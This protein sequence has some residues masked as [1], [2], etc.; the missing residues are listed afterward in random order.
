[1]KTLIT[2]VVF[3]LIFYASCGPVN[4]WDLSRYK[5]KF[6]SNSKQYIELVNGLEA[7]NRKLGYKVPLNKLP[8]DFH[9]I[10]TELEIN[11][12]SITYSRCEGISHYQFESDWSTKAH[13]FFVYSRCEPQQSEPDH[14]SNQGMIEL[15]G[16]GNGWIM[17][18]DHDFI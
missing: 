17:M 5:D 4:D 7:Y 18:I 14:Y 15:W 1:M 6:H 13:L 16:L 12:V 9:T 8:N 10:L 3:I 2:I 11:D